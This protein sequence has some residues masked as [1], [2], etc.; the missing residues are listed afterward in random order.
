MSAA[1]GTFVLATFDLRKLQDSSNH[2]LAR[3]I[4]LVRISF[5]GKV[6][7]PFL[8]QKMRN[9]LCQTARLFGRRGTRA[10]ST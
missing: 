5:F 3:Q 4:K 8:S 2:V 6:L 1:D 7:A 10:L 9:T